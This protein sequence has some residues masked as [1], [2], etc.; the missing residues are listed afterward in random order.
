MG[1]KFKLIDEQ[2]CDMLFTWANDKAVR[3][4][5]FNSEEINY[6]N[7]REWFLNKLKSEYVKI[8]IALEND[9]A[10]GQI[11]IDI[12]E[13][14]GTIGYSVAKEFRGKGYGTKILIELS[15][16][17]NKLDLKANT[18]LGRVKYSNLASQRAFEKAGY[19]RENLEEYIEYTKKI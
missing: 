1:I 2:D 14:V 17:I 19:S 16:F 10:I 12:K 11:R 15:F 7:H 6:E 5:S 3:E 9:R 8:F 13:D 4:N 18:L